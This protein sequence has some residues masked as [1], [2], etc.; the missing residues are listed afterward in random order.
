[1]CSSKPQSRNRWPHRYDV[2][3]PCNAYLC[4]CCCVGWKPT[5]VN[6]TATLPWTTKR[7]STFEQITSEICCNFFQYAIRHMNNML[8]LDHRLCVCVSDCIYYNMNRKKRH[9]I[10]IFQ[11]S[12]I[13]S[14]SATNSSIKNEQHCHGINAYKSSTLECH[15]THYIHRWSIGMIWFQCTY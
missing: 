13:V 3:G 11:L 1:M 15:F 4:C 9:V 5:T 12:K 2:L 7:W 14:A 6:T 10:S 8:L